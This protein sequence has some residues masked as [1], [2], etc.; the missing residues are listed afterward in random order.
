MFS[1]GE[2]VTKTLR[3]VQRESLPGEDA[4]MRKKEYLKTKIS[5]ELLFAKKNSIR[6]KHAALRALGRK[7]LY[8]K[9]LKFMDCA[10]E[11]M[12][13]AHQHIE[14]LQKVKDLMKDITEEQDVIQEMS[15]TLYTSMSL[16][17]EF[18]EDELLAELEKLEKLLSDSLF[19]KDAAEDRVS[20]PKVFSKAPPSHPAKM[21]EDEIEDDLE[22]LRR[23]VNEP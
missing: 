5:Q 3:V 13:S 15:D 9:H 20:H 23:W 21:E 19:E 8:E 12:R 16:E 1:G 10:V 2:K 18:D 22:H 4:L 11:A 6:N 7:K 14:I 17:V